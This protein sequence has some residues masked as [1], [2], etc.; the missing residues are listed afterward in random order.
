MHAHRLSAYDAAPAAMKALQ[1]VEAY[2]HQCGLDKKLIELVKMRASQI[3]GC[4]YCLDMHSKELRRLG[5]TE[6]RIYLLNAWEESPLYTARE[7]AAL[8]WTEALT[9]IS[10]THA[11]DDV[12]ERVRQEFDDKE[13]VDLTTL[14]GMIN[15]WNRLAISLRYEHPVDKASAAA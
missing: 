11:P 8:A 2:L 5:E 13:L 14:V 7:R 10:Q 1:N 9:L 3:N 6:Q 15:L 4:A 12:Y